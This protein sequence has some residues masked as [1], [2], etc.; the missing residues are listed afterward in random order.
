M[1]NLTLE[2]GSKFD[3]MLSSIIVLE[4]SEEG[5]KATILYDVGNGRQ[6]DKLSD[7]Y[8]FVKKA[9]QDAGTFRDLLEV[10][11]ARHDLGEKETRRISFDSNRIKLRRELKDAEDGA[12]CLISVDL[13]D[14]LIQLRVI[15]TRDKLAGED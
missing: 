4:E 8:G 11:T 12:N 10:N 13:G 2:D 14:N 15:E 3:I 1:F 6:F 5:K 7:N 9:L